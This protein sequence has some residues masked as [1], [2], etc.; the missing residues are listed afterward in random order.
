MPLAQAY[1]SDRK[2]NYPSSV[3]VRVPA[4]HQRV[5]K[6]VST[7]HSLY[8]MD[9][10]LLALSS[11]RSDDDLSEILVPDDGTDSTP[12]GMLLLEASHNVQ[13]YLKHV[14]ARAQTHCTRDLLWMRLLAGVQGSEADKSEQKRRRKISDCKRQSAD[15][16]AA[17]LEANIRDLQPD[18][19]G[20]VR[21]CSLPWLRS[22]LLGDQ[23]CLAVV[24]KMRHVLPLN[25]C[26]VSLCALVGLWSF[27]FKI[28][29]ECV[30]YK[31][32]CVINVS[33]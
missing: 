9:T 21:S 18:P 32:E 5:H 33:A 15:L 12:E 1:S 25:S 17:W 3:L 26:C 24:P 30:A 7:P 22:N 29:S 28:V 19:R 8:S 20:M 16:S 27:F 10:E 4:C 2:G 23:S 6:S 14:I 31:R 11:S 13:A